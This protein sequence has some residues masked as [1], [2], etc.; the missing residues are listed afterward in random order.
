MA[1][2]KCPECGKEF[3]DKAPA[4]PNCGCPTSKIVK[5]TPGGSVNSAAERQMLALVDQ[6]LDKA[7]KAGAAY[8]LA[9]DEVQKLAGSTNINLLGNSVRQDTSRIVEAAV[10][11]CDNLY[12]AY[13]KLI[14]TLDGSCRPL[15]AQNPGAKAVKAV[16]GTIAWLNDES[17]IENNYAIN[18]N[19]TNLGNAVKAKYIPSPACKSIQGFWEGEFRKYPDRGE[20]ERFWKEK[21]NKHKSAAYEAERKAKDKARQAELEYRKFLRQEELEEK[22]KVQEGEK[23]RSE[24]F[25]NEYD[26][27]R[28]RI[29][30]NRPATGLFSSSPVDYAYV[31]GDGKAVFV[32][33]RYSTDPKVKPGDVSRMS[34]LCQIAINSRVI[35]GLQK[36]GVCVTAPMDSYTARELGYGTVA[37]WRNIK[38]I[39]VGGYHVAALRDNETCVATKYKSS[40]AVGY[41]G[42]GDVE[43]WRDVVDIVCGELFTAGLKRDGRV[44]I[45]GVSNSI[46]DL[47]RPATTWTDIVL[48]YADHEQLCGLKRDGS[49]V[50]TDM[51]TLAQPD[52]R[53]LSTL[54]VAKDIVALAAYTDGY[55]AL[56][57]DGNVIGVGKNWN[58]KDVGKMIYR[59]GDA[60]ALYSFNRDLIILKENGMLEKISRGYAR[61]QGNPRLFDSYAKYQKAEQE[62]IHAR[63]E[64]ERIAREQ[65]EAAERKKREEEALRADR[66]AKN[67]CQHCGGELEKKLFGWKCKSCGQRKDY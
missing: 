57:S 7:R 66:R 14:P 2:I 35:V 61:L 9:A 8:E 38:K 56:Q 37:T 65:R 19:G 40:T 5:M 58:D 47:L 18:F 13:Q 59:G 25:L 30:Y 28:E 41:Y 64:A 49:L 31:T 48:L 52:Q 42:Q 46:K 55:A 15:L 6:T 60:V 26:A 54:S 34:N 39:A 67:L 1:L 45:A 36:D 63:E 44:L 23:A 24:R 33:T 27:I 53:S 3:S 4:C 10:T 50:S 21:L 22:K 32:G 17:E 62:R 11:A 51:W 29:E 20:A 43:S 12:T 16:A